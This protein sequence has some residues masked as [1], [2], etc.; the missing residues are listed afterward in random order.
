MFYCF[1]FFQNT[2]LDQSCWSVDTT[3][4]ISVSILLKKYIENI[5]RSTF[6]HK[7]VIIKDLFIFSINCEPVYMN[8]IIKPFHS[9]QWFEWQ[10]MFH[11]SCILHKSVVIFCLTIHIFLSIAGFDIHD[12]SYIFSCRALL[13][14]L[15]L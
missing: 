9:Q 6:I 3:S 8:I 2:C 1:F 13:K 12:N 15:T 4:S 11:S 10:V 7:T 14:Q 5:L